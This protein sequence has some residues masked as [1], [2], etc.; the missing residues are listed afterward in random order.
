MHFLDGS[1]SFDHEH[2][3]FIFGGKIYSWSLCVVG[4]RPTPP[5]FFQINYAYQRYEYPNKIRH[6]YYANRIVFNK[7]ECSIYNS[8]MCKKK[9]YLSFTFQHIV[10]FFITLPTKNGYDDDDDQGISFNH[11]AKSTRTVILLPTHYKCEN[12]KTRNRP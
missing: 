6:A 10:S 3:F 7:R 9:V 4:V 5:T 8:W 11:F 1:I 2:F 12:N